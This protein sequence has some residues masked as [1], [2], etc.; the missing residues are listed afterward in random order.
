LLLNFDIG[1]L[2]ETWL[3]DSP[4]INFRNYVCFRNDRN[5]LRIGEGTLIICRDYLDPIFYPNQSCYFRG[6][7]YTLVSVN[8]LNTVFDRILIVSVYKS[9]NIKFALQDWI[10]LFDDFSGVRNFADN[11]DRRS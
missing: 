3:N 9:P 5:P 10:Q 2:E 4:I 7:E 6:C 11:C 1:C 8:D